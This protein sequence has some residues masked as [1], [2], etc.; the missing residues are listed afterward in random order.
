MDLSRGSLFSKYNIY[1]DHFLFVGKKVA[2]RGENWGFDCALR[3]DSEN[4]IRS[5]DTSMCPLLFCET[6]IMLISIFMICCGL[7]SL[8]DCG[9]LFVNPVGIWLLKRSLAKHTEKV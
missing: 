7:S 1:P 8:T 6:E 2:W 4:V 9:V 3:K 5:V